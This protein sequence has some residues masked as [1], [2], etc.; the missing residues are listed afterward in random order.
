MTNTHVLDGSRATPTRPRVVD[1]VRGIERQTRLD[2]FVG[3]VHTVARRVAPDSAR[4]LLS[5][6]WLGHALHPMLTDLPLGCWLSAGALD[7][8]GGR[9]S[10]P[11]ARRLVALGVLASV[12]AA[13]TGASDFRDVRHAT[14]RRVAAV[15]GVGNVVVVA[16]YIA[17]WRARRRD[18]HFRGMALA[19]L[20]A[21]GTAVTGYLGGH[22]LLASPD[23]ADETV[24]IDEA[25]DQLPEAVLVLA[26]L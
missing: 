2:P 25:A 15:H 5:G 26:S 1:L 10:R 18:H 24:A 23:A 12:P 21:A 16:C 17:S 14:Q 11:A 9:Q 7:V 4:D 6:K 13:V 3:G 19:M 20:G 8:V 22:L